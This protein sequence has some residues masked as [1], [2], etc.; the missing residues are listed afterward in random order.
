MSHKL[1]SKYVSI[2]GKGLNVFSFQA[3]GP[4]KKANYL[5]RDS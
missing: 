1:P 2:I 5:S 3:I 4:K